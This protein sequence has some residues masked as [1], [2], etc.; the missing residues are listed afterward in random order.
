MSDK[1]LL[2][3]KLIRKN[4]K[5]KNKTI[6]LTMIVKNESKIIARCLNSTKGLID[7]ICITDTGSTDNTKEE[8]EKWASVNK[9]PC[10]IHFENFVNFGYNRTVSYQNAK[11]SFPETDYFLLLDADMILVNKD[12]KKNLLID[13]KYTLEQYDHTINYWNAR[14]LSNRYEWEC[15]GVTHEFWRCKNPEEDKKIMTVKIRKLYIDDRGDG[16]AK[17]D[18]NERDKRLL[19]NALNDLSKAEKK[20]EYLMTRYKF[21][22]AQTLKIMGEYD[23]SI[24]YYKERIADGGW[25]EEIFISYLNIGICYKDKGFIYYN[26]KRILTTDKTLGEGDKTYFEK[27]KNYDINKL[28]EGQ[29]VEF[30]TKEDAEL[31]SQYAEI[32]FN[33]ATEYFTKG[34]DTHK[35]RSETIYQLA[36]MNRLL[37][38]YDKAYEYAKVGLIIPF[39]EH[40]SL[41]VEHYL[42]DYMFKYELTYTC[43][44]VN[45]KEEGEGYLEELLSRDDLP[46]GIKWFV[47]NNSRYYL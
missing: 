40:D 29:N 41:F 32:N 16:G 21:Y 45:K 12:F 47:K 35:T 25:I 19:L 15:V 28:K 9:I 20:D 22:L 26:L 8:I 33:L 1:G 6:C 36:L 38:R 27:Y 18:K 4:S 31:L 13:D 5:I 34:F 23:D 2:R 39:P 44:Y 14:I 43:Y 46:E 10:Q 42:Y 7:F 11:K 37:E 3:D 24:K 17:S 30:Y